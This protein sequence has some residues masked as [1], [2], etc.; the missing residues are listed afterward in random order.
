MSESGLGGLHV[1]SFGDHCGGVG[2]AE[3]V[4]VEAF[5]A[6]ILHGWLPDSSS[7]VGVVQRPS[8]G[9]GEQQLLRIGPR[10]LERLHMRPQLVGEF[11]RDAD[12]PSSSGRLWWADVT[13]PTPPSSHLLGD[14]H[15][16]AEHIDV[17]DAQSCYFAP[18]EPE[19][20]TEPDHR[21]VVGVDRVGELDELYRT[22]HGDFH[23]LDSR[24]ADASSNIHPN[25]RSVRSRFM[26]VTVAPVA[27]RRQVGASLVSVV[28]RFTE[29][30]RHGHDASVERSVGRCG[31]WCAP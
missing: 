27:G 24:K 18:A 23:R 8:F 21:R 1:D 25:P 5:N 7:P 16:L 28:L 2:P 15:C 10:Q 29:G 31:P 22:W 9:V 3:V 19:Y 6:G 20:S 17:P 13:R 30:L 14:R 4:E 11:V 26:M 12:C